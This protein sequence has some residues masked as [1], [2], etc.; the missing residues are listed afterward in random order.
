MPVG[1]SVERAI[2]KLHKRCLIEAAGEYVSRNSHHVLQPLTP[3]HCAEGK[4]FHPGKTKSSNTSD[5]KSS[6]H[7]PKRHTDGNREAGISRFGFSDG[8]DIYY[9]QTAARLFRQTSMVQYHQ[10]FRTLYRYPQA[11][12]KNYLHYATIIHFSA[13]TVCTPSSDNG[14]R[15]YLPDQG[16]RSPWY[17]SRW[18]PCTMRRWPPL[19]GP[20]ACRS[21]PRARQSLCVSVRVS[22]SVSVEEST[23]GKCARGLK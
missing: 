22:V 23:R 11:V 19:S 21:S 17:C 15:R 8:A 1:T 18:S 7:M 2:T 12:G 3:W 5:S 4:H 13:E 9:E 20:R 6:T 14:G 10:I 16:S